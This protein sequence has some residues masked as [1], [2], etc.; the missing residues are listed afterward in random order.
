MDALERRLERRLEVRLVL[1]GSRRLVLAAA[2]PGL[3]VRMQTSAPRAWT[4]RDR[5]SLHSMEPF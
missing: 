5:L 2:H 1:R 4:R 3:H